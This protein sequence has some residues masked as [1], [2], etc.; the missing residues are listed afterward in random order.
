[1]FSMNIYV[2]SVMSVLLFNFYTT[3][4]CLLSLW[5]V[6]FTYIRGREGILFMFLCLYYRCGLYSSRSPIIH[7]VPLR[8][9]DT[10]QPMDHL[11]NFGV[12]IN[13]LVTR[14]DVFCQLYSP[15]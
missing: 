1:M 14:Y 3:H 12:K 6:S 11:L 8:F 7:R 9:I 13:R 5:P 15:K 10:S 4:T 2:N